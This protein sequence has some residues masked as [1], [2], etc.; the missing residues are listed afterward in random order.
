MNV[1]RKI[2]LIAPVLIIAA[3]VAIGMAVRRGQRPV[4]APQPP[5]PH[6]SDVAA[7]TPINDATV[8]NPAVAESELDPKT[9]EA[10]HK[11]IDRAHLKQIHTGLFAYKKVH[12]HFPEY[13][14]QLVPDF[15]S[16]EALTSPRKPSDGN[17]KLLAEHPDPGLKQSPYAYEFS[18]NIIRDNRTFAQIKDVQRSEWGDV[19]PILRALGY[20]KA[21]NM[22]YGGVLFETQMGWER[23]PETFEVVKQLGWGPGLETGEYIEVRVLDAGNQPVANT[24]VWADGR[25]FSFELPNRPFVTNAEGIARIPLGSDQS[26]GEIILRV[27]GNGLASSPIRVSRKKQRRDIKAEPASKVGGRVTNENDVPVVYACVYLKTSSGVG[28]G[29]AKTDASGRWTANLHPADAE[30]F[31][32]QIIQ[33]DL[34]EAREPGESVNPALAA[35]GEAVYIL[36]WSAMKP[37]EN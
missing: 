20:K 24:Q 14:S 26:R 2:L 15:V 22:S 6:S 8:A 34:A 1:P 19:V 4:E 21:I 10:R 30:H 36:R 18:N 35:A 28:I 32:M 9:L 27:D 17:N 29:L 3:G 16:P 23:D 31:K 37:P 11:A 33:N 13:L 5:V 7:P 25:L 12:G